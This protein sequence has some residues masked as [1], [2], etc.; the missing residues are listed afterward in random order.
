MKHWKSARRVFVILYSVSTVL[1]PVRAQNGLLSPKEIEA[2]WVSKTV[3][4][5]VGSGPS[6]GKSIEFTMNLDGTA[7]VAGAVVDTGTW[8]LSESGYC[9][10]WKKIRAG[11]ERCFTVVRKGSNLEVINPDGTLST[12]VTAIR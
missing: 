6:A 7:M 12:T 8:R 10:T 5:T 9:A 3:A 4:G 2:T 11:Q 1:V